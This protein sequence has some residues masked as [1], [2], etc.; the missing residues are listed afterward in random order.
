MSAFMMSNE[1]LSMLAEFISRYYKTD[2]DA[3]S[4][5][6]PEELAIELGPV[7]FN[8]EIVFHRLADL[9]VESLR[10][11]YPD[12]YLEMAENIEFIPGCDIWQNDV[13]D[14]ENGVKFMKEW[15]Y[16]ILKSLD[17]YLYQSCEGGC[18]KLPLYKAI[19]SLRDKWGGYIAENNPMYELAKWQ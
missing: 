8:A 13:Y 5:Y 18:Y 17:C 11:R 19:Q 15:H 7:A 2:G 12:F 10:R 6:F 14:I 16:Q 1:T 9:N 3:F 4:F